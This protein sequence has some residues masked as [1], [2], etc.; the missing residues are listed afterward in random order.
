[1]NVRWRSE[2]SVSRSGWLRWLALMC[3]AALVAVQ[4][5]L[6]AV[7]AQPAHAALS[8]WTQ[9]WSDE[10][11]GPDGTSPDASPSSNCSANAH[12]CHVPDACAFD[13]PGQPLPGRTG[14][15]LVAIARAS[16]TP[17]TSIG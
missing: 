3:L 10:F 1:M 4:A 16:S 15:A 11:N 6:L 9:I 13:D 12:A 5:A 7:P 8:S 14:T 2:T 17:E